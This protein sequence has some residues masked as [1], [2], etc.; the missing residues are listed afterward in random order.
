MADTHAT[1]QPSARRRLPSWA[2]GLLLAIAGSVLG[3]GGCLA[4]LNDMNS[5]LGSVGAMIFIGGLLTVAI[6]GIWFLVAVIKAMVKPDRE[7]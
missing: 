4:F 3:L 7:I 5:T 2:Q 6:G 1:D